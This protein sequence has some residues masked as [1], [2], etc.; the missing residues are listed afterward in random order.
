[1]NKVY[2]GLGSNVDDRELFINSAIEQID[3]NNKCDIIEV[4][5]FYETRPYGITDQGNFVNAVC[6]ISTSLEPIK[7][8]RMIKLIEEQVGRIKRERWGPREIDIDII[9]YDDLIIESEE[10]SIPHT[11]LT[12]RAFVLLPVIE[13]NPSI[14]HPKT[15]KLLKDYLDTSKEND[16]LRIWKNDFVE[17]L[18]KQN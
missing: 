13:L 8:F 16:I 17:R 3:D 2:L 4:S 11:D 12:N 5:S 14:I 6:L 7:L 18:R 10:L 15:K 9:F 1:M